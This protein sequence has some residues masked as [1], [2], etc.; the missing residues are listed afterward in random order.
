MIITMKVT[1]LACS[2]YDGTHRKE[3][4][5]NSDQKILAIRFFWAMVLSGKGLKFRPIRS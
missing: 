4:D 1:S 3:E 5:L 2:V